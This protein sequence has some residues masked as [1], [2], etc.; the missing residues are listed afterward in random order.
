MK[1]MFVSVSLL[2]LGAA[3]F[4]AKVD[5]PENTQVLEAEFTATKEK[6]V[7]FLFFWKD[8]TKKKVTVKAG[9]ANYRVNSNSGERY[10]MP[11]AGYL[12]DGL[13]VLDYVR[14]NIALLQK[15]RRKELA[16]TYDK[17]P[18]LAARKYI[19]SVVNDYDGVRFYVNGNLAFFMAY[20]SG[21]EAPF[22]KVET[23]LPAKNF[24]FSSEKVNAK[25]HTLP[26]GFLND[27]GS[28]KNASVTF[29]DDGKVPFGKVTSS[30]LDLGKTSRQRSLYPNDY[31][32]SSQTG[33]N[34]FDHAEASF[35]FTVPMRQYSHIW[36]LCAADNNP[37]KDPSFTA[38]ITR[39]V[40]SG[41]MGGRAY[42]ALGDT[43]V[44]FPVK[45]AEEVGKVSVGKKVLPLWRVRIPL[46]MGKVVDL[47]TD[48][49]GKYRRKDRYDGRGAF[50]FPY[51][52]I[53]LMGITPLYR[54]PFGDPRVWPSAEKVSSV[55]IFGA[56][57]E[58]AKI[59]VRFVQTTAS[60]NM[61]DDTMKP[62]M[63]MEYKKVFPGKY[64]LS[65]A[66]SDHTGKV[67]REETLS[68]DGDNGS[69][70]ID[71]SMK[72]LGWYKV[73]FTVKDTEKDEAVLVH[74]AT[75][76]LM[77]KD[78]R[79]A[80]WD[81]PYIGWARGTAHYGEPNPDM[82]GLRAKMLGVRRMT[83]LAGAY[84][85]FTEKDWEKYKV[86]TLL[87]GRFTQGELK[88]FK[89]KGE[90][91]VIQ[92]IKDLL[93]KFPHAC[94]IPLLWEN[95][96]PFGAYGLAPELYG[97]KPA[98]YDEA[99]KKNVEERWE[100]IQY[101][102]RIVRK[103]FP[104]L[105]IMYGNSGVSTELIAEA[106]RQKP[107]R[108][109]TSFWG[110]E[111]IQR[112]A[113]PEK[114][115]LPFTM[116]AS[117]EMNKTA[118]IMGY[119]HIR[120]AT[121]PENIARK[122]D[123]LGL[124]RHAEW[125]VR[126]MLVQYLFGFKYIAGATD[127]G[128]V[129]NSYDSS[130]Y[131]GGPARQPYCYPNP[132]TTATGTLT[133]VLDC[134]EFKKLVP[135]SSRT[136]YCAEFERKYDKKFIYVFWTSR[137]DADLE[138]KTDSS[139]VE[140]VEFHGH[141]S[142]PSVWFGKLKLTAGTAAQYVLTDKPIA[143]VSITGRRF[144]CQ[145]GVDPKEF[146][147]V[148]ALDSAVKW[149]V[150]AKNVPAVEGKKG[151]DPRP[152]AGR[153]RRL[154]AKKAAVKEVKDKEQ[155]SCLALSIDT[156][157]SLNQFFNEYMVIR[158]DK[159]IPIPDEVDTMGIWVKGNSG[160]GQ[161][162]FELEDARG[163]RRISSGTG[164]HGGS[165]LSDYTGRCSIDFDGA[166]AFL[167]FPVTSKSVLRDIS[168]GTTKNAWTGPWSEPEMPCKLTGIY[169]MAPVKPLF[170]DHAEYV[171]QT[172]LVKNVSA[173]TRK[174]EPP[175]AG[176]YL[177][178]ILVLDKKSSRGY[179]RRPA[180]E[181]DWGM[182]FAVQIR[183]DDK[184]WY[185]NGAVFPNFEVLIRD[186]YDAVY[187][188][189]FNITKSSLPMMKHYAEGGGVVILGYTSIQ[190]FSK[191]KQLVKELTGIGKP[192]ALHAVPYTQ[193]VRLDH[194]FSY[195]PVMGKKR[196][197]KVSTVYAPM[198][199]DLQEGA[200]PLIAHGK[201]KDLYMATINKVGSGYV[202]FCGSE[203]TETL[204]DLLDFAFKKLSG[205]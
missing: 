79:K 119:G 41:D 22:T 94:Q 65:L 120:T 58:R 172:I 93:E 144:P 84:R 15:D 101:A 128:G 102:Q 116:M 185:E 204:Y 113:H 18:P 137:G 122:A 127:G 91:K 152:Y 4:A 136:V 134:V 199:G 36:V 50:N 171:D 132:S 47:V 151:T 167:A 178:K 181:R 55:H 125:Y 23:D 17:Q 73:V 66:I 200:I 40:P 20:K 141:S 106:L 129:G 92:E 24:R 37:L 153:A 135:T 146:Q 9:D 190:C 187:V 87:A 166:W 174:I 201:E 71:L 110:T 159:P 115:F 74:N 177:R 76:A 2:L 145:E 33:R 158:P 86:T 191:D 32:N 104:Q 114:P 118:E 51:L 29:N 198:A 126:D 44:R 109:F 19:F 173:R 156:D 80:L 195:L 81:S 176:E 3:L 148:D 205:K 155:G 186:R 103:H 139:D 85:K 193:K 100:M 61:F 78:T 143:S 31:G 57:L 157:K 16:K 194:E 180:T 12:F 203:D 82:V 8:G 124:N 69:R 38:R 39:Y 25:F 98:P 45:G 165:D 160:W 60:K 123:L 99:R 63:V 53:E 1:K 154:L 88:K 121:G 184:K 138:I 170:H 196:S 89:K 28:F 105:D 202:I 131:A 43:R 108:D 111:A 6:P 26:V 107:P 56:A 49:V 175:P 52:D 112:S 163:V 30:N 54:T 161:I 11:Q 64:A 10:I 68:L 96:A 130:F 149:T 150:D 162:F 189:G 7:S 117:Y 179:I 14:C 77:G 90:E 133:K 46:D 164:V 197:W 67:L 34:A 83:G 188:P 72:K 5:V 70:R 62:E 147:V 59:D 21:K 97:Y 168:T 140:H 182:D 192:K 48:P 42:S 169:F 13:G 95:T 75:F 27:P 35:L 183:K 142:K